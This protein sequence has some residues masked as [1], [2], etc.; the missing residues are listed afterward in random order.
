[1]TT[2]TG[3]NYVQIVHAYRPESRDAVAVY[4]RFDTHFH[5]QAHAPL[6]CNLNTWAR[7]R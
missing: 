6:S 3:K 4:I 1:M 5:P 7:K 2:K